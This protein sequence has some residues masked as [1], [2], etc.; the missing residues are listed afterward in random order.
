MYFGCLKSLEHLEV[1]KHGV[2]DTVCLHGLKVDDDHVSP[3]ASEL[4][5]M[6]K[7][8]FHGELVEPPLAGIRHLYIEWTNVVSLEVGLPRGCKP[9]NLIM[10]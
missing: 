8:C 10:Q 7:I 2:V 4:W 6:F 5:H 3:S 1:F 9:R